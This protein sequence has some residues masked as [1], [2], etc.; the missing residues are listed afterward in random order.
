MSEAS[1]TSPRRLTHLCLQEDVAA[2]DIDF[3]GFV[4]SLQL[5]TLDARVCPDA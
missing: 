1:L 2:A 4:K 3:D 5:E